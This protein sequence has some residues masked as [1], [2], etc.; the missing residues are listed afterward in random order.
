MDPSTSSR[1]RVAITILVTLVIVLGEFG[2]LQARLPPRRPRRARSRPRTPGS[3]GALATWQTGSDTAPVEDA[4][5][6]PRRDRRRRCRRAPAAHPRPGP[7]SLDADRPPEPAHRQRRPRP[8]DRRRAATPS[9][10]ASA[11]ILGSLLV[12]VSIGWFVWFR[13]L[14]RRHRERAAPAH[15]EA[16]P[17]LRRAP[18][19]RP[20][21][22]Q[23]RPRRV[24]EPDST[25]TFVSPVGHAS[26]AARPRPD[27]P[28][29]RRP[30]APPRRTHVHPHAG[31]PRR[32]RPAGDPADPARR[33][34]RRSSSR[35]PS[36][37]CCRTSA[38]PA[39]C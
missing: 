29:L 30:A 26:S 13:R 38:V 27:R 12:L 20:R 32:G 39:G 35:A 34:P 19:A 31:R 9:T 21:A 3:S 2:F 4:V 18:A 28:A 33:R 6:D 17:R 23:R 36:T 11:C 7:P 14:V 37:T 24:L 22:E 15:R 1:A 5:R 10:V 25:A 16:G 8:L